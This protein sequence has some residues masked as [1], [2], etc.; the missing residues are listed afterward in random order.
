[1]KASPSKKNGKKEKK[2]KKRNTE[3]YIKAPNLTKNCLKK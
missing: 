1:M 2:R 3:N